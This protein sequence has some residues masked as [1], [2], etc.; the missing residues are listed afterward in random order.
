MATTEWNMGGNRHP[1]PGTGTLEVLPRVVA[2]VPNRCREILK[3]KTLGDE[4]IAQSK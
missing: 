2:P 1:Y 3:A 4:Q